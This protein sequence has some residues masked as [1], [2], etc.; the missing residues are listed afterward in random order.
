[1]SK[2]HAPR[3]AAVGTTVIDNSSA[4]RMDPTKKLVVPE[5]NADT[6]TARR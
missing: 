2:E 3:F 6:L 4:W 5:L 1:M